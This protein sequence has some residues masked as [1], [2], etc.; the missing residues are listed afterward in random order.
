MF[1]K[2]SLIYFNH[3]LR[4]EVPRGA[5]FRF[6]KKVS[7][8]ALTE[9]QKRFADE[10]LTDLNATRA[11]KEV[12]KNCKKDETASA[13]AS[14][15]LRNVSVSEYIESR[16]KERMQRTE[17]TQDMVLNELAAIAFAKA[18]DYAKVIK[19][20][21]VYTTKEGVRIPLENDDGTPV[22]I[23]D[24][25]LKLT[26]ELT[27]KQIRAISGIK[28]GKYGIEVSQCDKVRALEL[29]G[30]HLGMFKDK[31]EL[32]GMDEEKSKLDNIINQLLK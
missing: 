14:R 3:A 12:Y 23:A 24:V 28:H 7:L 15:L 29:L 30:R 25:E 26:D 19:T 13:A 22:M 5:S 1:A 20:Q 9:N 18:S 2:I 4:K 10:Y 6:G 27:E 16:I 11:Y 17:I 21:A 31:L 32:S 8:M